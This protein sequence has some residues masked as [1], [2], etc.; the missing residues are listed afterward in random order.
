MPVQSYRETGLP[1]LINNRMA[2]L[3]TSTQFV[4]KSY[5]KTLRRIKAQRSNVKTRQ[6]FELRLEN[7]VDKEKLSIQLVGEE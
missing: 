7:D 4:N 6:I 3:M 1:Q 2:N 5:Q